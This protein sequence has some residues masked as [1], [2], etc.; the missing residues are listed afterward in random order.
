[1]KVIIVGGGIGGMV[2]ALM[3]QARGIPFE[4]YEQSESIRELGVGINILPSAV[5]ELVGLGLL[6]A[7]DRSGVRTYELIYTSFRGQEV[8]RELRG[9]HA[10]APAPQFSIHRGRLLGLLYDAVLERCG[11]D[12]VRTG[13]RLTAFHEEPDGVVATFTD[14]NGGT[15]TVAKGDVLI[16]ADGIHSAVRSSLI[17]GEGPPRWNGHMILRG[18][19]LWPSFLTGR[20]MII[21][22]GLDLKLVIYPI[23]EPDAAGHWLTNWAIVAKVGEVGPPPRKEDWSRQGDLEEALQAARRF[24]THDI[25]PVALIRAADAVWE[26]PMCDRDPLARWSFGRV[27]LLGDA[28]HPMYPV[29]SNGGTQAILDARC[30]ADHLAGSD[31]PTE[32]L[33]RYE[34]DRI[35]PTAAI[36]VANRT[37]GPEG[38]IDVVER[39]APDGFADIEAVLPREQREAIVRGKVNRAHRP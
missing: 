36:V 19:S 20:S 23:A 13:S 12:A 27:S 21:A 3:L 14:R 17:P 24:G 5:G 35:P 2:T 1:M 33:A 15:A 28:A 39:L 32:A 9:L 26:Y 30:L 25:H 4:V 38:V 31:D 22:G 7:L 18:V 6:D 11:P 29:G 16:G 10:G 37:G 34:A 8:W